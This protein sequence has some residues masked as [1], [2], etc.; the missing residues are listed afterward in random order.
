MRDRNDYRC[1]TT[2][3]LKEEARHALRPDWRELCIALVERVE[4]LECDLNDH[5]ANVRDARGD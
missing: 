2:A 1:M 4:E 5:K 3:Q